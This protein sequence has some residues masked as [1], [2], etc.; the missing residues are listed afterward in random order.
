M[1]KQPKA[2][3][4]AYELAYCDSSFA[5]KAAAELRRL[6]AVNSELLCAMKASRKT[7]VKANK[8]G[9]PI[10]DTIWHGP[11]ETLFDFMDAA[12]TKAEAAA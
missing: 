10:T 9:G 1:S 5:Y 12:I 8:A 6:H 2:L 4:L 3:R 7:L 11:C